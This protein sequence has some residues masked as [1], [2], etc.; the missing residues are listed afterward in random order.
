MVQALVTLDNDTNR[1]LNVIK[2][3]YD[4]KDKGQAIEVL[5]KSYIAE[6][7]PELRPEFIAKIKKS[8]K[9]KSIH[10]G[11]MEDFKKHFERQK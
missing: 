3:R 10:I 5:A 4:L 6:K 2:A 8:M 9:E 11:S 7:E 1:V